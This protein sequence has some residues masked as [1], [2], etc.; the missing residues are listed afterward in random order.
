V[1]D[2]LWGRLLD[3]IAHKLPSAVIDQWVR[4]CRLLAV[5]G[6]HLKVGAPNTFSRD[7]LIQ[8]HFQALQ[9]AA[10]SVVG[11]QPRITIVVDETAEQAAAGDAPPPPL[12]ARPGGGSRRG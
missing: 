2:S 1:L 6:D 4:P 3:A 12:A 10:Q 7:W 8:H 9:Q 5:E 11:G